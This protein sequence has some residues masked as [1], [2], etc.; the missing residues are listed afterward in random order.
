M[1]IFTRDALFLKWDSGATK[2][3]FRVLMEG[4]QH[5][6]MKPAGYGRSWF[7][8]RLLAV[9]ASTQPHLLRGAILVYHYIED[10]T[11]QENDGSEDID[12]GDIDDLKLAWAATDLQAKAHEDDDYWT[13]EC[14]GEWNAIVD[15]DPYRN[16]AAV[17]IQLEG[18]V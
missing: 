3:C 2:K 15:Y 18:K 1:A 8:N 4:Y 14:V 12:V 5:S 17:I 7:D 11:E 13:A 6:E 10:G 9:R 16:Y